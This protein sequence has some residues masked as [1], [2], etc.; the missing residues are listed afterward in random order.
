MKRL[1]DSRGLGLRIL[2]THALSE[3][4]GGVSKTVYAGNNGKFYLEVFEMDE[5]VA[6]FELKKTELPTA[7]A[8]VEALASQ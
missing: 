4:D 8:D 7:L 6:L 1:F 3:H 5:G 2:G